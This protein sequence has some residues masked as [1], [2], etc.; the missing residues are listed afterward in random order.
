VR[1]DVLILGAGGIGCAIAWRLRQRGLSVTLVDRGPPGGEASSAA[2]GILAPQAEAKGPGPLLELAMASRALYPALRDELRALTGVDVAY[3]TDGTLVLALDEEEDEAL[4]ARQAWQ[5]AA[6][7]EVERLTAADLRERE[8]ALGPAVSAL[9]FAGDHQVD[10]RLLVAALQQAAAQAGVQFRCAQARR[11]LSDGTRATGADLDGERV[12]AGQVILACGSWSSLLEGCGL[13]PGAVHP[14]RGQMI[15]LETRPPPLRHVVFGDHGYLVP[16]AD[17][18]V[19]CGST[20]EHV[21][22]QKEVTAAGLARLGARAARLCPTLSDA[23]VARSWAG[24]RP[25][26]PDGLPLLGPTPLAGLHLATGHHRNGILLL[27]ITAGAL[28]A[29]VTGAAPPVE[30]RAFSPSRLAG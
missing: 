2:A 13:A 4:R 25:G 6:G 20:E 23:R 21:G 19:L 12:E 24:F 30:L 17:G 7:L 14:V 1:A 10:N 27:P 22:W 3:R 11:I 16:R 28:A 26:T 18:R 29:V 5:R 8:P 15:E 9:R